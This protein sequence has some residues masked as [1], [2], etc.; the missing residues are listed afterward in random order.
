VPDGRLYP[1]ENATH[2]TPRQRTKETLE[3]LLDF[4][5]RTK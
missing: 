5:A 4:E 3:K 2:E 1:Y